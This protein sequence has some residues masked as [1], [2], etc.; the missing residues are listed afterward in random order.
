[1]R[2]RRA[3]GNLPSVD[4]RLR[5]A[6][7]VLAALLAAFFV[8]RGCTPETPQDS[9]A[10]PA[11]PAFDV[12]RP[13]QV[14]VIATRTSDG[15]AADV[16]WL[17]PELRRLLSAAGLTIAPV[18]AEPKD[19]YLLR[20][21]IAPDA[22]RAGFALVA[23]D[24]VLEREG[25]VDLEDSARLTLALATASEL[26]KFLQAPRAIPDWK[27][28]LGTGDARA[29]DVYTHALND[30]LGPNARGFTR[31]PL[32]PRGARAL[33]RLE[34]LSRAA[35]RFARARAL[36]AVGYLSL[37]GEDQASLTQLAASSAERALA[38]DPALADAQA[39]LGLAALRSADWIAAHERLTNA[40]ELDANNAAAL[41]GLA[42]LLTDAGLYAAA[43]PLAARAVALLPRSIGASECRA[44]VSATEPA[45]APQ[46]AAAEIAAL[47]LA[48]AGQPG[49]AQ[50]RLRASLR[51]A[52]YEL[53][54]QPLSRALSSGRHIPEAL[55]AI[56]RAASEDQID[57]STEIVAG[58]ALKQGEF[59]LNRLARL[60]RQGEYAPLRILWLPQATFLRQHPRF[61]DVIAAAG[62]T[63][64]WQANG[65]PD[66]CK[67]EP[68]TY[69]CVGKEKG[70][71]TKNA[72]KTQ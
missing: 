20:V 14:A 18:G 71:A 65:P 64:F 4:N 53:W 58:T 55:R 8:M 2:R 28:A 41:E 63:T 56:T 38:L 13:L 40:L 67:T 37:G 17:E 52:Q 54:A 62:L 3:L 47:R 59:V 45:A 46:E 48:L 10:A 69:G 6:G 61:D 21:A 50:Q 26:A 19:A 30:V 42:C 25:A 12:A 7:V 15:K 35:P 36:L 66:V 57:A 51:P 22:R 34:G 9:S 49:E 16:A 72:K 33:E 27:A 68:T 11:R 43:A 29:Y 23:P 70:V 32:A 39:A 24:Q 60:Q 31:P 44:Y 5:I 1:L